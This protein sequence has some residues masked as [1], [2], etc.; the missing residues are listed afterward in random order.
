MSLKICPLF[1]IFFISL[2]FFGFSVS[3]SLSVRIV[4]HTIHVCYI[5]VDFSMKH[6]GVSYT[7]PMD[8]SWVFVN[9]GPGVERKTSFMSMDK[10][11]PP[12][13]KAFL[14]DY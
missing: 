2:Q 9:L 4:S 10:P 11:L 13:N 3:D 7:S 12:A 14:R 1:Q 6:V 8:A 5:F